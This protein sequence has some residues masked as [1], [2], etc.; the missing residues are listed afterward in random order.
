MGRYV[1]GFVLPIAKANVEKYGEIAQKA[2]E[3]WKEH[4]ALEYFEVVGDD[5]THE[6]MISFKTIANASEDETVILAWIV[7]ES[8]EDRDRINE[9]VMN[10]PRIKDAIA[11]CDNTFDYKRMAYG[12]FSALVNV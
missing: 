1:D 12:G 2:G 10:D 5:L 3:V 8:R 4:G 9:A 6:N 11:P 7:Y